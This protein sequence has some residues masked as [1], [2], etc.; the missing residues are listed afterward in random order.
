MREKRGLCVP[1]YY[2]V[3]RGRS[4]ILLFVRWA[5]EGEGGLEFRLFPPIFYNYVENVLLGD[6]GPRSP[7]LLA[8]ERGFCFESFDFF[9]LLRN[10]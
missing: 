4:P 1:C 5:R 3:F 8:L 2:G 6:K 7:C 10:Q 9:G